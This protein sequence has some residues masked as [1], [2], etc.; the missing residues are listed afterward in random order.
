[1]EVEIEDTGPGIPDENRQ[2]IFEPFFTTKASGTGL[3]LAVVKRIVEGHGGEVQVTAA[4]ARGPAVPSS[5]AR[6]CRRA[7][8]R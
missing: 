5:A 1:M 2:R 4:R 7:R 3:G 8:R 6:R